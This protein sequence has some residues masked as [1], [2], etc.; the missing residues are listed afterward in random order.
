[1]GCRVRLVVSRGGEVPIAVGSLGN[2]V[3]GMLLGCLDPAGAASTSLP[4]GSVDQ[5]LDSIL[6]LVCFHLPIMLS[7]D[8]KG[9]WQAKWNESLI[10]KTEDRWVPWY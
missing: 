3:P 10:A 4:Q 5:P 8:W 2:S 6:Y 1:M 7:K 9:T